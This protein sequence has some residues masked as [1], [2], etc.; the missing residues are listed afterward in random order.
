MRCKQEM[1]IHCLLALLYLIYIYKYKL[2]RGFSRYL[3]Y[4]RRLYCYGG[5]GQWN[6]LFI[7]TYWYMENTTT[8][9]P[10]MVLTAV[11]TSFISRY[12]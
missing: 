2:T 8:I 12:M 1:F 11:Q 7:T 9:H 6:D 3:V 5:L 4:Y 10:V